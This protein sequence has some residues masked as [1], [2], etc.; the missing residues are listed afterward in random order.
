[1]EHLTKQLIA[2]LDGYEDNSVGRE[3]FVDVIADAR[4]DAA[5]AKGEDPR[6]RDVHIDEET[7]DSYI[8]AVQGTAGVKLSENVKDIIRS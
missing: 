4:R 6:G 1:M 8:T 5:I 3:D 7:V 2:R